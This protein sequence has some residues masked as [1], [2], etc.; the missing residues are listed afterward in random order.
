[1]V[2]LAGPSRNPLPAPAEAGACARSRQRATA[3]GGAQPVSALRPEALVAPDIG[4]FLDGFVH[5]LYTYGVRIR[6]SATMARPTKQQRH[7]DLRHAITRAAWQQIATAGAS[8]LSLRAIARALSISAPAIYHYFPDRDALVTALI[9][10]AYT[11]FSDHQHAAYRALGDDDGVGRL[12]ATGLA[13]RQWALAHPQH[14]QLIFGAPIPGYHAPPTVIPA[15]TQALRP[16]LGVVETLR[17]L[18]LLRSAG[19]PLP[20][21]VVGLAG[22]PPLQF[23]ACAIESLGVALLIWSRVHGLVSLELGGQLPLGGITG[24]ELYRHELDA[25]ERQF[26]GADRDAAAPGQRGDSA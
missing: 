19:V 21:S 9:I 15:A 5:T 18:G 25:I 1:M 14:Y 12:R 13:Y 16:L 2:H 3:S 26:I 20:P 22:A 24:G 8:A 11:S 6:T 17:R 4:A 10:E 23:D 7:P